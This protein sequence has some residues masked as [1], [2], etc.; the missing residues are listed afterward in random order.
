MAT[1]SV[2][3]RRQGGLLVRPLNGET[4]VYDL[5]RHQAHCLNVTASR[6]WRLCDGHTNLRQIRKALETELGLPPDACA[7]EMAVD[8]FRH[9]HLIES[10]EPPG[11]SL[12]R[13][14]AAKRLAVLGAT[15]LLPV[16]ISAV[17]PAP[18][19]AASCVDDCTGQPPG[20]PCK[21]PG[22]PPLPDPCC[23]GTCAGVLCDCTGPVV[24]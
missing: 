6:V 18:A 16:V 5:E 9:A 4:I 20:T 22:D 12:D 2:P 19:E 21:C 1:D 24:C 13:R 3:R 7:V 17:A 11:V 10:D 8:Q 14:L 15:A 23:N